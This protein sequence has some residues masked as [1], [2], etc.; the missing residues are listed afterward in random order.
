MPTRTRQ[1]GEFCW[2]NMITPD[3]DNAR[4]FFSKLLGWTYGVIP[5]MGHFIRVDG[6]DV[7][8]MFDLNGPGTPPGTEA[9]IGVMVLVDSADDTVE[10]V[11]SL[12][13][14][15]KP[16][17]DI[18]PQGRMAECYDPTGANFDVWQPA[19]LSASNV[20]VTVHGAPGWFEAMTTD[21]EK[22]SKFY[23]ELFGWTPEIT[24]TAGFDYANFLMGDRPVAG[25]M[26]I[27][28]EKQPM[29]PHWGVYFT[30]DDVDAT[31]F[32][33]HGLGARVFVPARD[34][35]GVGR[36]CGIRS[37]QGVRFYAIAYAV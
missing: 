6:S 9:G 17:F 27:P 36:F 29:P 3:P 5:G 14:T 15:A 25:M 8:G 24:T 34:I 13:G 21:V 31:E 26:A 33:A 1:P 7:G 4:E 19:K 10:K 11:K 22:A 32:L 37:P 2:I 35:P 30:V 18:G 12:G 20:D 23:S 16:A 28:P